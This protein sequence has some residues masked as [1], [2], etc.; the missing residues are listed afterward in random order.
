[1]GLKI[2]GNTVTAQSKVTVYGNDCNAVQ[3]YGN[4]VWKK[5]TDEWETLFSGKRM[6]GKT[7]SMAVDGLNA[8][9]T[10]VITATA[11]FVEYSDNGNYTHTVSASRRELPASLNIYSYAD[12]WITVGNGKVDFVFTSGSSSF[13]GEITNYAPIELTITEIRRK[14]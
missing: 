7:G 13:K 4:E 10:V 5:Q 12:I 14:R 8:S 3:M 2:Q 6:F 11:L 1:M 9:D